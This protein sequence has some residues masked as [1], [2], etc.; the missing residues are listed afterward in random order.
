[1]EASVPVGGVTVALLCC[2]LLSSAAG[3]SASRVLGN[4]AGVYGQSRGGEARAE[5][6]TARVTPKARPSPC[7]GTP[8]TP[9]PALHPSRVSHP[10]TQNVDG[11]PGLLS[12][13]GAGSVPIDS[14]QTRQSKPPPF[15]LLLTPKTVSSSQLQIPWS[16]S[17]Q[18]IPKDVWCDQEAEGV[19]GSTI[20]PTQLQALGTHCLA[21]TLTEGSLGFCSG[22]VDPDDVLT[23]EEQI[24]L[25]VEAKEKCQRDIKAQLEKSRDTS[26]PPEWDGIICWPRGSPSQEV[27]VPCPD[28]IYDFNHKGECLNL[29][30]GTIQGAGTCQGIPRVGPAAVPAPF[31]VPRSRLQVLQCLRHLG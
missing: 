4:G 16:I 15:S 14:G 6:G 20:C 10:P 25:L 3:V 28:Y 11:G 27:S 21:P 7:W 23:K 26:C 31:A 29:T 22:Q 30:S 2:C 18:N 9:T 1:M 5:L 12:G 13:S 17:A 24:Y 8:R 19:P